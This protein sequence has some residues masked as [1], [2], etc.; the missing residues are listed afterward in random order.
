MATAECRR[1]RS[2]R[3]GHDGYM[4]TAIVLFTRDLRVH[5]NPTLRAAVERAEQVLPVFVVDKAILA[6]TYNAPNRA[7][8]LSSALRDLDSALKDRG[9]HGLV[10][11]CGDS[12]EEVAALADEVGAESVHLSADWTRYAVRRE[13]HLTDVLRKAGRDLVVHDETVPVVPPAAV[14]PSGKDH[15]AVFTPYHR[16]WAEVGP[17]PVLRSPRR[18]VSPRVRKGKVPSSDDIC[19]GRRA[20]ALP[21]GGETAGR[22]LMR[23]WLRS[24]VANYADR[25][26]DLA[27]DATSRLSPYLHFG[28]VSAAE[29]V[30]RADGS[31][32]AAAFVRQLAW[33]DFHLQVLAARPESAW[34]DYR[35]RGD[36]WRHSDSDLAAWQNGRTGI[37]IVDAAMRQLLAEGWMHNRGRLLVASFLTKTLYLD[38]REGA[39]HFLHHL[40]DGDIANN[41]MNWQ[42]VAGTGTDSRP[43]RVL[44][45][46]R[47]AARYDPDGEFVRRYVPE[48]R[49]LPDRRVHK[50]WELSAEHRG[51]LDYPDPIVDL[52]EGRARFL[53][54]RDT[55]S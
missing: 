26:D 49:S 3:S 44:N 33:R 28:C 41:Q 9:A 20:R 15:F 29:L 38:W 35:H 7:A 45:P 39:R 51:Q 23:S 47:Q 36:H 53:A 12:A 55:K 10:V 37:P 34:R 16:K 31:E 50:P 43:N 6:S 18:L 19:P 17:R 14:T 40:V 13:L 24:P 48:L 8:F 22:N 5:D 30:E 4:T 2:L 42:W 52:D 46:I 32:G 25:H 54:T 11:R 21:D 27:G 1:F